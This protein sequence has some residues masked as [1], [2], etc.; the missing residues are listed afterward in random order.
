MHGSVE[1]KT[2]AFS[3]IRHEGLPGIR[4]NKSA[5]L[6]EPHP[7]LHQNR[8]RLRQF[9]LLLRDPLCSGPRPEQER[10]GNRQRSAA[11]IR[12]GNERTR[13]D[14]NQHRRLREGLGGFR[15]CGFAWGNFESQG[16]QNQD[17]LPGSN[18][19]IGRALSPVF[20]KP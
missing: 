11:A 14:R 4:R 7:G 8:R 20:G 9:L 13:S 10:N 6:P 1:R 3:H 16:F 19:T 15:F 2:E 17:F 18:A 5:A 12:H